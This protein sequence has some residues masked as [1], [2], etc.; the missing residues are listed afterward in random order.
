MISIHKIPARIWLTPPF[1]QVIV[2]GNTS[3]QELITTLS[4]I[5]AAT[6]EQLVAIRSQYNIPAFPALE[7]GA[8]VEA[9]LNARQN[10]DGGLAG[11]PIGGEYSLSTPLTGI[12]I[13]NLGRVTAIS[14]SELAQTTADEYGVSEEAIDGRTQAFEYDIGVSDG[15]PPSPPSNG[16]DV[17]IHGC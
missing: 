2:P 1:H 4:R 9:I 10:Q 6:P 15:K 12:R 7:G 3:L 13:G 16:P 11:N 14:P 5:P 17:G 8:L